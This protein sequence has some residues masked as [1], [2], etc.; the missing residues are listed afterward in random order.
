MI[1][2]WLMI[3]PFLQLFLLIHYFSIV[4]STS[5]Q[6]TLSLQCTFDTVNHFKLLLQKYNQFSVIDQLPVLINA[7]YFSLPVYLIVNNPMNPFDKQNL[8]WSTWS[9]RLANDIQ[10]ITPMAGGFKQLCSLILPLT[11]TFP[12]WFLQAYC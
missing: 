4:D 11:N 7:K 8:L 3:N 2:C 5:K 12:N 9:R 6:L 10:V 1:L